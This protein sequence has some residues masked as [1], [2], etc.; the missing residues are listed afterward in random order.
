VHAQDIISAI[1]NPNS[2]KIIVTA[3]ETWYFQYESL[4]K[5]SSMWKSLEK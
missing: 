2:L 3:D 5:Q 1:D 4:T